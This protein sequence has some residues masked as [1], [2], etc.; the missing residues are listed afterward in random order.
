MIQKYK[1]K[2]RKQRIL[3]CYCCKENIIPSYYDSET[4]KRFVSE[5]GKI[6]SREDSGICEKHQKQLTRAVKRARF[7][8]I[9]PFIVR[10]S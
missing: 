5:R 7:L 6:V 8:A 4:L 3:F 9:L 2:K 1:P 10:P